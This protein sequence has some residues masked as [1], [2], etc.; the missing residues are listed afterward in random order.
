[1]KRKLF[2]LGVKGWEQLKDQ[3]FPLGRIAL[4]ES[5]LPNRA[6]IP[7][8]DRRI[9]NKTFGLPREVTEREVETDDPLELEEQVDRL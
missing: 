2:T 5:F 3:E 9:E 7:L 1:M 4:P 8:G 6:S